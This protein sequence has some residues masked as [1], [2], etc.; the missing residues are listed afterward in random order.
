MKQDWGA[1][2]HELCL[3]QRASCYD[4]LDICHCTCLEDV[5]RQVQMVEYA[6]LQ[7]HQDKK[8]KG[9]GR[10][11]ISA[12]AALFTGTHRES[13]NHVVCPDLFELCKSGG[14]ER[15][16]HHDTDSQGQRGVT[17]GPEQKENT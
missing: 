5:V 7:S 2:S 12:E 17:P 11:G 16:Q 6:H 13:E 3:R 8:G 15:R 4:G 9:K 14:R 1:E 10:F